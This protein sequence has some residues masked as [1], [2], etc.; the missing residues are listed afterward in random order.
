M[1]R[2]KSLYL[3]NNLPVI[4]LYI[5]IYVYVCVCVNFSLGHIIWFSPFLWIPYWAFCP[6]WMAIRVC[7]HCRNRAAKL[8]WQDLMRAGKWCGS[9]SWLV[10]P[11]E[12]EPF[13][14]Q[15]SKCDDFWG[16][17]CESTKFWKIFEVLTRCP[18]VWWFSCD[19]QSTIFALQQPGCTFL[20]VSSKFYPWSIHYITLH[21]RNEHHCH[22]TDKSQ[23]RPS[24]WVPHLCHLFFGLRNRKA[25]WDLSHEMQLLVLSRMYQKIT[26]DSWANW[27]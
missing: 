8:K 16:S 11:P 22:T 4:Y 18:S 5:Y 23:R 21:Y 19:K 6:K 25:F 24:V 20:W 3:S 15:G 26:G 10:L 9:H 17:N 13:A 12:S 1:G 2:D 7:K 27:I 14:N